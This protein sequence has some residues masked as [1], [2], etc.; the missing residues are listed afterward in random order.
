[1]IYN[2]LAQYGTDGRLFT[3]DVTADFKVTWHKNKAK[4]QKS[5]P[6]KFIYCALL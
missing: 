3:T 6:L 2:K 4:Y 1:V 5:D